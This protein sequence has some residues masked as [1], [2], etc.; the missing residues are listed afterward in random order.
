M[1]YPSFADWWNQRGQ[2]RAIADYDEII[3]D[4]DDDVYTALLAS[5]QDYNNRLR[6]FGSRAFYAPELVD[7]YE[8]CLDITGTGIMAY[9]SI[10]R[11]NVNLPIY[12]G[13]DENVLQV[14]AGHL[15]GTSLPVG[16]EGTHCVIMAHRGLPSA[17]LFSDLDKLEVGDI[18][19][20]TVLDQV[21]TYQV[22]QILI[23]LPT[24]VSDL[25]IEDGEDYLTLMTCT[26]YGVNSHRLLV[27]GTRI[28]TADGAV[29]AT[30]DAY[31]VST[32]LASAAVAVILLIL[33]LIFWGIFARVR[34]RWGRKRK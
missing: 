25:Q 30:G 31:Q 23:V 19:T 4:M 17:K 29:S 3:S 24:E 9:I 16:G 10:P 26:P 20:V 13:T 21:L 15:E 6:E 12:H 22:D 33:V 5:A 11:I 18:F 28:E 1:I 7:G 14:A 32:P 27:R 8:D 34:R 2:N